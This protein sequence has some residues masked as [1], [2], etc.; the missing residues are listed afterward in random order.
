MISLS[1][2]YSH[3]A[4]YAAAA[5]HWRFNNAPPSH[6]VISPPFH[7]TPATIFSVAAL[8]QHVGGHYEARA[9]RRHS[10]LLNPSQAADGRG[11]GGG[12]GRFRVLKKAGAGRRINKARRISAPEGVQLHAIAS[13]GA[14]TTNV[15]V[16]LVSY[17]RRPTS[18]YLITLEYKN[19]KTLKGGADCADRLYRVVCVPLFFPQP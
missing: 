11:G 3:I 18:A 4:N 6:G 16:S 2:S 19:S 7:S 15:L 5:E 13:G 17:L 9:I 8:F 14:Q 1:L 12:G 10:V